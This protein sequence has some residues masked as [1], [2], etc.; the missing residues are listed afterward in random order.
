VSVYSC[1]DEND[2][3]DADTISEEMA[4]DIGEDLE[5]E[6][7]RAEDRIEDLRDRIED[8]F[9]DDMSWEDLE[10]M[11][12]EVE[13]T[14][15]RGMARIGEL[16]EEIGSRIQEDADVSVVDYRDFRSLLA[17][18][19]EGMERIGMK[20]ANKG[21]FGMRVSKLE[22]EYESEDMDMEIAILDLGTMKGLLAMG[23]DYIDQEI[24]EE[25]RDGFK[26]TRKFSGYPGFESARYDGRNAE[27]QGV[28]IIEERFVVALNIEGRN[29]DKDI[30]EDIFDD[31]P[32]RRLRRLAQ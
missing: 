24:D 14:V 4:R 10:E 1:T 3:R 27:I 18:E 21:A 5:Q 9:E 2:R 23:F 17:D 32:F 13:E 20:G 15:A 8:R 29:V 26:R 31:F 28:V 25:D 19:I 12:R 7:E 11:G 22:A 6:L 30:V 16:L